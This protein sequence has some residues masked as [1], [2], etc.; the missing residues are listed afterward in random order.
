[1]A[2][3]TLRNRAF[4]RRAGV[5]SLTGH[6]KVSTIQRKTGTKMIERFLSE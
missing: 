6:I 1:M 2:I 4:E 3:D 5:A